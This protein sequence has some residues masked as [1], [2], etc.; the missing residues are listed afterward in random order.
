MTPLNPAARTG[1]LCAARDSYV[2]MLLQMSRAKA[3]VL[4]YD[5]L[6]GQGVKPRGPLERSFLAQAES[7][8]RIQIEL[9]SETPAAETLRDLLPEAAEK[10]PAHQSTQRHV[11]V[12]RLLVEPETVIQLLQKPPGSWPSSFQQPLAPGAAQRDALLA[13]VLSVPASALTHNHPLVAEGQV[14]LQACIPSQCTSYELPHLAWKGM[15]P[16]RVVR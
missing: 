12:N 9:I 16:E 2:H 11:R 10:G 3:L 15:Q 13:D 14:V 1:H 4:L 8:E 5:H 6:V 7:F